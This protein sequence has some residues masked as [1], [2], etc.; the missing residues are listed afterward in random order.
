D[1]RGEPVVLEV[2]QTVLRV[3]ADAQLRW[4]TLR[5]ALAPE[6]PGTPAVRIP[7]FDKI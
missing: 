6:P 2:L 5:A 7:P 3:A 1:A 4:T